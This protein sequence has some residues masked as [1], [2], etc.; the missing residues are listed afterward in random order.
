M[1]GRED[2]LSLTVSDSTLCM[3]QTT[4]G[5]ENMQG[6]TSEGFCVKVGSR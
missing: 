6:W 2:G 5:G 1:F 3:T 4:G